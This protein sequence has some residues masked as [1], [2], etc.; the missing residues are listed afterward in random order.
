MFPSKAGLVTSSS[1]LGTCKGLGHSGGG[2]RSPRALRNPGALKATP[3][4]DRALQPGAFE[5][6]HLP[7]YLHSF[8]LRN[9]TYSCHTEDPGT[10]LGQGVRQE[11]RG[12]LVRVEGRLDRSRCAKSLSSDDEH[13]LA[14]KI[15]V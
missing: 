14:V 13:G 8:H 5:P 9:A 1:S 7:G 2:T 6:E 15:R 4:Q 10:H 12:N 11:R 3:G